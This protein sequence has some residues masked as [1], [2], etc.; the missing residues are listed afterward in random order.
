MAQDEN[1]EDGQ[2]EVRERILTVVQNFVD[3]GRTT[4]YV[5]FGNLRVSGRR[6]PKAKTIDE[7]RDYPLPG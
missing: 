7:G 6:P 3:F 4:N 1:E 2:P 5:P